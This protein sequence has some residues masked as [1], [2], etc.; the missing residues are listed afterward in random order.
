VV[1]DR[2]LP[3]K[4]YS[5]QGLQFISTFMKELYG[6]LGVKGN[7]STA[8]RPQTDGQMEHLSQELEKYLRTYINAQKDN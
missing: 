2:G 7:P 5:D 4:V 6:V 1:R 8:Y 3:E